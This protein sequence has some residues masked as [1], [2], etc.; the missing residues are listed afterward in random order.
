MV[1]KNP[2]NKM[3]DKKLPCGQIPPPPPPETIRVKFS[4]MIVNI[5]VLGQSETIGIGRWCIL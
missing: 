5:F 4:R 1:R 3:T 2:A